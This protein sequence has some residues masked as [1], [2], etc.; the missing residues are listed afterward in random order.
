MLQ[1]AWSVG[2]I[3]HTGRR[4]TLLRAQADGVHEVIRH[5]VAAGV[6]KIRLLPVCQILPTDHAS[7]SIPLPRSSVVGR[8]S[9]FQNIYNSRTTHVTTHNLYYQIGKLT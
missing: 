3:W 6:C 8:C 2:S 5:V 1:E 7:C 9:T 4:R